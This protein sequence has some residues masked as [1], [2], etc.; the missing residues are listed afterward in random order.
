MASKAKK[1]STFKSN[2]KIT[3][4]FTAH[5]AEETPEGFW[6]GVY[7]YLFHIEVFEI[8]KINSGE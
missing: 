3:Y 4:K 6:E 5:F 2:R 8:K 7:D 1:T